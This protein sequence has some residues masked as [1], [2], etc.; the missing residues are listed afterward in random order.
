MSSPPTVDYQSLV[1]SEQ[2]LPPAAPPLSIS[3]SIHDELPPRINPRLVK[4]VSQLE[5]VRDGY[6]AC[7]HCTFLN[8][9]QMVECEACGNTKNVLKET[10]LELLDGDD[11]YPQPPRAPEFAPDELV[12]SRSLSNRVAQVIAAANEEV[13]LQDFFC[14]ICQSNNPIASAVETSSICHH[15]CCN[16][17]LSAFLTFEIKEGRVLGMC[18]PC[19]NEETK[20]HCDSPFTNG[21][22]KRLVDEETMQKYERFVK[23]K[24]D[25]SYRQCPGC[26]NLIKGNPSVPAMVCNK[27]D[28]TFCYHHSDAHVGESCAVYNSKNR[29]NFNANRKFVDKHTISCPQCKSPIIKSSGCNHM[30][31]GKCKCNF[32]YLCGGLYM[33]G[34]HFRKYPAWN[35]LYA[36]PGKQSS[37]GDAGERATCAWKLLRLVCTIPFFVCL[38]ISFIV[39]ILLFGLWLGL[40]CSFLPCCLFGAWKSRNRNLE[41]FCVGPYAVFTYF[42]CCFKSFSAQCDNCREGHPCTPCCNSCFCC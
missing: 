27:C 16:D 25:E 12:L 3:L 21:L 35:A 36:C 23:M 29:S 20:K 37:G 31:C 14:P 32:C 17:C 26:Q 4:T 6:W 38:A 19:M 11:T 18:C 1:S 7:A 24:Q 34:Q 13:A 2:K 9:P 30:T 8:H 41:L 5:R 33:S 39:P 42:K 22:I 40:F 15:K 28:R 10:L